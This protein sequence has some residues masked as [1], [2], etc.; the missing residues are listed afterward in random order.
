MEEKLIKL[1]FISLK[2]TFN[3]TFFP[4]RRGYIKTINFLKSQNSVFVITLEKPKH[5]YSVQEFTNLRGAA[6]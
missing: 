5:L 3:K 6:C 1:F 2:K 4:D